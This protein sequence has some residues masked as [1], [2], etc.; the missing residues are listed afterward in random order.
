MVETSWNLCNACAENIHQLSVTG[1]LLSPA[2]L[3]WIMASCVV[4]AAPECHQNRGT[5]ELE[6]GGNT[7]IDPRTSQS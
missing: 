4:S 5:E 7:E 6:R 3:R 1:V 2:Q